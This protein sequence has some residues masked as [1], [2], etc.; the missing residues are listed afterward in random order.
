M[1]TLIDNVDKALFQLDGRVKTIILIMAVIMAVILRHWYLAAGLWLSAMVLILMR[2]FPFLNLLR[3]LLMPFSI[4]WLVLLNFI[5][6][7]GN[8]VVAHITIGPWVLPIYQEGIDRGFLVMARILAAVSLTILLYVTTHMAEIL[9]TFRILKAPQ[10]MVDLA[11]MIYRYIA[12]TDET[13]HTMRQAQLSRGGGSLPWYR[14]AQDM[15]MIAGGVM[16][17]ALDRS[18]RIYKAMLSR[19]FDENSKPPAYFDAGVPKF[20]KIIGGLLAC[21]MFMII[22]VDWVL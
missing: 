16:V 3:K 8:C 1:N 4:A 9:A 22:I 11:E 2:G 18:T 15:G 19:G 6:T 7:F 5:F 10:L 20:D 17:K 12:I 14:Q 21:F 13:A